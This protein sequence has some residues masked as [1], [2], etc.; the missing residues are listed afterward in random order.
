MWSFVSVWFY[1]ASYFQGSSMFSL[2][3]HFSCFCSWCNQCDRP[4]S[5]YPPICGP[6][7]CIHLL[8]AV[9][10]VTANMGVCVCVCARARVRVLWTEGWCPPQICMLKSWSPLGWYLEEG[11]L[12]GDEVMGMQ[13]VPIMSQLLMNP[14]RNHEV[15]GSVPGLAQWVKDPRCTAVSCGVGRR[16]SSNPVLLWLWRRPVATAP[17]Q[18]QQKKKKRQKKIYYFETRACTAIDKSLP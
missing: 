12:G 17:I 3:Q 6:S 15:E 1:L 18:Q 11:A 4:R 5:V 14:T 7:G 2:C 10:S 8:A 16:R 9:N 13:G